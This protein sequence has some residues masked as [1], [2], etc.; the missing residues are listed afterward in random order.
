MY[1]VADSDR[2]VLLST[3]ITITKASYGSNCKG[4]KE[5]NQTGQLAEECNSRESCD[6][7]VDHK[8]IGDPAI[9]CQ[10]T[11]EVVYNCREMKSSLPAEASGKK[12]K[13]YC[14]ILL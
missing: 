1:I 2:L 9:G 13:L 14:T 4:V 8:K 6:Y 11:Y 12:L 3:G 5:G 10:K 7:K